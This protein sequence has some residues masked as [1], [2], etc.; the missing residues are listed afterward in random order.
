[1]WNQRRCRV[2]LP[3]LILIKNQ[4]KRYLYISMYVG[5][6]GSLLLV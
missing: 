6:K 3:V 2:S 1:M 5:Y 4:L